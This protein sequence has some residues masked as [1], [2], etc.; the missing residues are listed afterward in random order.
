MTYHDMFDMCSIPAGRR[1]AEMRMY[2]RQARERGQAGRRIIGSC[3]RPSIFPER[4]GAAAV[5][6]LV[7]FLGLCLLGL[8]VGCLI[9]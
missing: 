8:L 2:M 6:H 5:P 7:I 1:E 4:G 3:L 9:V